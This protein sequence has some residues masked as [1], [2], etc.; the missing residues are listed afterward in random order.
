M[1]AFENV[2]IFTNVN[3]KYSMYMTHKLLTQTTSTEIY[4]SEHMNH[5]LMKQ[6]QSNYCYWKWINEIMESLFIKMGS[7]IKIHTYKSE[8]TLIIEVTIIIMKTPKLMKCFPKPSLLSFKPQKKR[9]NDVQALDNI[10]IL[11]MHIND[12]CF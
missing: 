5:L 1:C 3:L 8:S 9:F 6:H 10:Q 2:N 7:N 12:W 11:W 4:L